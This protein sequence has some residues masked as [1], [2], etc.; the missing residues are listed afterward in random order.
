MQQHSRFHRTG[1]IATDPQPR[2]HEFSL[3]N[4]RILQLPRQT[5][6]RALQ[7]LPQ[8]AT[9]SRSGWARIVNR[10]G[11][12]AA[13]PSVETRLKSALTLLLIVSSVC[14]TC[15]SN[16]V[17]SGDFFP[18]TVISAERSGSVATSAKVIFVPTTA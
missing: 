3:R 8:R 5:L 11:T 13:K 12:S 1:K 16:V 7:F 10:A 6:G 2:R 18:S 14:T 9:G 4:F 15:G 17:A